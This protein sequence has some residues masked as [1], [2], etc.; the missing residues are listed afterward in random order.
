MTL[1]YIACAGNMKHVEMVNSQNKK[2][3]NFSDR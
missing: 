3:L 1:D 2:G